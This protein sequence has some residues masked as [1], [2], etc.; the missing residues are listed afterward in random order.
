MQAQLQQFGLPN[1][2]VY[3]GE[4]TLHHH[5]YYLPHLEH[6]FVASN[7]SKSKRTPVF[8][9]SQRLNLNSVNGVMSCTLSKEP[10][11][12]LAS[13]NSIASFKLKASSPNSLQNRICES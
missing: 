6:N 4:G 7:L 13:T 12:F 11:A 1:R 9:K 3:S 2:K 5:D 8:A 10:H